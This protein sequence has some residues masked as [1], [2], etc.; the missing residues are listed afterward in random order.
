MVIITLSVVR[1]QG[2][3]EWYDVSMKLKQSLAKTKILPIHHTAKLR[4]HKH[5]SYGSLLLI[6]G[7]AF[8]CVFVTNHTVAAD[9]GDVQTFAVVPAPVYKN[10]PTINNLKNGQTFRTLDPITVSGSC[11]GNSLV[12]IYKNGVM[13]GATLCK[14][15]SYELAISLFSGSNSLVARALNANSIASPDSTPVTVQLLARSATSVGDPFYISAEQTYQAARTGQAISWQ[16][17]LSGG[18]PPYALSVDWGDGETQLF[19]KATPGTYKLEHIYKQA[20][21]DGNY[22]VVVRATD[23][24][25]A[26]SYLQLVAI[27]RGAV[28]PVVATTDST[29]NGSGLLTTTT[30]RITIISLVVVGVALAGFW[31][32]EHRQ[33]LMVRKLLHHA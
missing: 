16:V 15:G 29:G 13:A 2:Y 22:T 1:K 23:Q 6:L 10:A 32:G 28:A 27:I 9:T 24:A 31:I 20:A 3:W 14:S 12:E 5:T 19:S 11:P 21:V 17:T 8:G 25:G 30:L 4:A 7:L 33:E 18:Q 26:T